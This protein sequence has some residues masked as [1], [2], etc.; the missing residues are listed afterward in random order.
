MEE[1]GSK[2]TEA[3]ATESIV[4]KGNKLFYSGSTLVIPLDSAASLSLRDLQKFGNVIISTD[5]KEGL[6]IDP[7]FKLEVLSDQHSVA[8]FN[9][10]V[11][12]LFES[13]AKGLLKNA[14]VKYISMQ[15]DC[16]L[17]HVD[18]TEDDPYFIYDQLIEAAQ[19]SEVIA[20]AMFI[21]S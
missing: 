8:H 17:V 7:L 2:K 19:L 6:V 13:K 12:L 21:H 4:V 9:F 16:K 1:N 10:D 18:L 14:L 20:K 15:P 3:I 11:A 5:C